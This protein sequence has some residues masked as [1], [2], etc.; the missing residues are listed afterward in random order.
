VRLYD[1][2]HWND[3]IDE[4]PALSLFQTAEYGDAKA[5]SGPWSVERVV[6]ERGN[7]PIAVAQTMIRP[8]P[9]GRGGLAWINR[10]PLELAHSD[11][12]GFLVE[13]LE[14]LRA[15]W[16]ERRHMYLRVAP[17]V[18]WSA[19]SAS[20]LPPDGWAQMPDTGWRASRVDLSPP[21]DQLRLNLRQKWRNCLNKAE[22]MGAEALIATDP[23]AFERF[24]RAYEDDLASR[25]IR[26]SVTPDLL[27]KL[28]QLLPDARKLTVIEVPL[29]GRPVGWALIARY[30]GV[31]EYLAGVTTAEGRRVNA[32]QLLLWKAVS[33]LKDSGC[34]QFDLGGMDENDKSS[35]PSRF[36]AGLRGTPYRLAPELEAHNGGLAAR[37]VRRRVEAFRRAESFS[38]AR[39]PVRTSA[40]QRL[41]ASLV[42]VAP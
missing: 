17:P 21:L 2:E 30:G 15:Y 25:G 22:R 24:L 29:D 12:N 38:N 13:A 34:E 1:G 35:G 36:K 42:A 40:Q 27:R 9:I 16:V 11:E 10:G 4:S 32:G 28:E 31:G 23:D 5:L 14:S 41:P 39:E 8:L 7:R 6:V 26:K 19:P 20:A 3:L 37:L 18:D 33:F